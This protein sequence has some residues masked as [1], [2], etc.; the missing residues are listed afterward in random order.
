MNLRFKYFSPPLVTF[1]LPH[2]LYHNEKNQALAYYFIFPFKNN[3]LSGYNLS[4]VIQKNQQDAT[5]IIYWSPRSA[6]HVSGNLLPIFR[7]VRLRFLQHM[8]SCPVVAVDWGSES[9][10]V[11]PR[12]TLPL[13]EPQPTTTIGH[14][15][16]C[17]KNLGLT[18]LNCFFASSS[19]F[20]Y[21]FTYIDDARSN[22]KHSCQK[23]STH[24]PHL[25]LLL[26]GLKIYFG[27]NQQILTAVKFK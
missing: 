20:L 13:S 21:Y 9:G 14:D 23:P 22:T 5:I 18:L 19:S 24:V 12:A 17:C 8:V 26:L 27:Y 3:N 1:T 7:S 25:Q 16:I 11:A 15:T 2:S 6:Q 4:E 10:N